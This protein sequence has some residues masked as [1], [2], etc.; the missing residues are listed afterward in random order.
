ML[1]HPRAFGQEFHIGGGA[2]FDVGRVWLDYTFSAPEDGSFPG[3]KWG[4]GLSGYLIWGRA[5]VFRV[6]VAFSPFEKAISD[7]PIAFYVE[8]NLMF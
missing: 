2:F 5:A 8:D 1:W 7:L 4:T 6:E 3:L